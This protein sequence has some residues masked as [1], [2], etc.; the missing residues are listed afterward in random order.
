MNRKRTG[1]KKND[2]M[3]EEE[4]RGGK[5]SDERTGDDELSE[6]SVEKSPGGTEFDKHRERE[7]EWWNE[8]GGGGSGIVSVQG[9]RR[10]KGTIKISAIQSLAGN[11][12]AW[13][14]YY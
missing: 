14:L 13:H 10:E 4:G 11:S 12:R 6:D 9:E 1:R 5:K 8:R 2:E 7:R 3:R